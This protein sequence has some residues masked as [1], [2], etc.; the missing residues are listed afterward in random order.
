MHKVLQVMQ[1]ILY[2]KYK[3]N[4]WK[5]NKEKAKLKY[6]TSLVLFLRN[7]YKFVITIER[8]YFERHHVQYFPLSLPISNL[9]NLELLQVQFLHQVCLIQQWQQLH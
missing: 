7:D 1:Y 2:L 5:Y 8:A 6:C 3:N 4:I 9:L